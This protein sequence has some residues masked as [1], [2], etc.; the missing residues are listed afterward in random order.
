MQTLLITFKE[1]AVGKKLTKINFV[2]L[3]RQN[4]DKICVD[5]NKV[6]KNAG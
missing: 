4:A 1:M 3:S 6:R 2:I 5:N